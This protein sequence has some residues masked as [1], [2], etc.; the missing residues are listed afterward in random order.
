[1]NFTI[2]KGSLTETKTDLLIVNLFEGVKSP[3][4][5]TG[6]VDK[7]LNDAISN[8]VIKKEGFNGEYGKMYLLPVL[9]NPNFTK[10]LVV[11]LGK[12]NEFSLNKLRELSSKI[13]QKCDSL[14]NVKTVASLLQGAGV[15]GFDAFDCAQMIAEGTLIGSY[16]FDKYK[17][18]KSKNKVEIFKIVEINEEKYKKAEQGMQKG[19]TVA[20]A[21]NLTRNLANEPAQ[22]STPTKLAE[23]AKSIDG[24]ETT[25]FD[26]DEIEKMAM[27][28]FLAVA[29]G[30]S[31][32]PK[33]IHMKYTPANPKKKIAIIGKGLTFDAGGMDLKPPSSMLNM[34]DDMSAAAAM[35][36]IMSVIA[37]LKP[38]V[39]VHAMIAACENMVSGNSYKP[40]DILTA[41]NGK[42]IEVDN[43]DAEGRITL[44]D[45]ICYAE[46]LQ[47]DEIV[48][49]ATLTGACM[50]A[51]GS[52]ASGILGNNQAL[53]DSII[54]C[55]QRADEK[56]WQMPMFEEY[57]DSIKSDIADMKNTGS[58]YGGASVAAIFLKNF[59]TGKTPWAHIDIAGT[60][61]LE[62]A[63]NMG[64][65][66]SV[67]MGVRTLINYLLK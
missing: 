11:G 19:I 4:G 10:V 33:F 35:L 5:A 26:K 34:K 64:I 55:S 58:R 30:S 32:P 38:D 15:A 18:K 6:A 40:G 44:A 42:T 47:V 43:T 37:E 53:I 61:F 54:E 23:V 14:D 59:T 24:I 27:T 56:M 16:E 12:S 39:E 63:N 21:V 67:G 49:M 52:V 65:K 3:A 8:F 22:Y 29:K 9:D 62:K 28:A 36:G 31:Q 7:L 17:S 66:A 48:D 2:E 13:I 50:V 46:E 25:V 1:M 45:A 60:A 41:K 51:L 57:G 20:K